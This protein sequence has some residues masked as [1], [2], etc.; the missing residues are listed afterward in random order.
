MPTSFNLFGG[1]NQ[2]LGCHKLNIDPVFMNFDGIIPV[3][4]LDHQLPKSGQ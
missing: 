4:R 2:T 3:T 1:V